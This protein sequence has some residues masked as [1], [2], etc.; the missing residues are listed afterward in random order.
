MK[1]EKPE[2][3]F[4]LKRDACSMLGIERPALEVLITQGVLV[5]AFDENGAPCVTGESLNAY[6]KK[7]VEDKL[8][9]VSDGSPFVMPD[10]I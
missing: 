2:K 3:R 9:S 4:W 6:R 8:N 1:R 5:K 10:S 7:L